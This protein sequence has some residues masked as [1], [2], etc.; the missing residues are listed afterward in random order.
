MM[1]AERT[2]REHAAHVPMQTVR[3]A[4]T[5]RAQLRNASAT[6]ANVRHANAIAL[7]FACSLA[8]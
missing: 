4:R 1:G 2:Q 5:P 7:R 3:I 6:E 8:T